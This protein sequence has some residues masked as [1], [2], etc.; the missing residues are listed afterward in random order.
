MTH[1]VLDKTGTLTVGGLRLT[2]CATADG[3]PAARATALAAALE[4]RSEHPLARALR[5]A[6]ADGERPAAEDVRQSAGE[7]VAAR[8]GGVDVRVGRPEYVAE[9]AGEMPERLAAFARRTHATRS[10]G[11]ATR[12]AGTRCSRSPTRCVPARPRWSRSCARSA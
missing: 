11:W 3:A 4:A 1:V 10:S 8:V 2:G 6:A 9:L 7:G 12:T 5:Q